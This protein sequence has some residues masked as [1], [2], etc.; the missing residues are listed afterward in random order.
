MLMKGEESLSGFMY[1]IYNKL[2]VLSGDFQENL[3]S[4]ASCEDIGHLIYRHN[5]YLKKCLEICHL[6]PKQRVSKNVLQTALQTILDAE[7]ILNNSNNEE[8]LLSRA[9]QRF[10]NAVHSL[11]VLM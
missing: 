9:Q 1:F 7:V 2:Q 4:G 5:E 6:S 3:D 10:T 11:N 8:E